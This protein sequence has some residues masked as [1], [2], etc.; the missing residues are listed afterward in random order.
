MKRT[1]AA[2]AALTIFALTAAVTAACTPER[3]EGRPEAQA[4]TAP[5]FS[6]A[7]LQGH[8][9]TLADYKGKVLFLNFW[10]TWCPPCRKEI[11]DFIEAYKD[12]KAD[13]LEILGV[14]VD[15]TTGP[16]LLDWV[17]K[18]GINYPIA[19]VTPEIV[20]A[21]RPGEYIPATI[22][23]D[24]KGIIRHRQSELMDKNTLVELFNRFK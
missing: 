20:E 19:L 6:L 3:T 9:V 21:Y 7:D 1:I 10:A 2:T 4:E 23:I 18:T 16:S 13:G 5:D 17:R 15:Q 8:T 11:P 14:S 24:R 12:L 22:V